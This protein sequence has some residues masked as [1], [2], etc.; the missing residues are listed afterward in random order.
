MLLGGTESQV[1]PESQLKKKPL[2]FAFDIDTDNQSILKK[3]FY[4]L[5]WD[6]EKTK[7]QVHVCTCTKCS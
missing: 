6:A 3:H 1:N 4:L 2:M 7:S 5:I